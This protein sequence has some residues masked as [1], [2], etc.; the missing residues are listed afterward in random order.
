MANKE[1]KKIKDILSQY[2]E[3]LIVGEKGFQEMSK[4]PNASPEDSNYDRGI[5]SGCLS[6]RSKLEELF[7]Y[8]K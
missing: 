2:R 7:D 4:S 5:A 8:W 3:W 6:A 1:I